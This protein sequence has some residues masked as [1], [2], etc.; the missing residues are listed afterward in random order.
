MQDLK[1]QKTNQTKT[2]TPHQKC[3]INLMTMFEISEVELFLNCLK[4]LKNNH[5]F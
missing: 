5:L 2:N 1:R 4:L 3:S